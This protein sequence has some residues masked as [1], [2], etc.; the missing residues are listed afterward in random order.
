MRYFGI[1]VALL[2]GLGLSA[3]AT[4]HEQPYAKNTLSP[5][6]IGTE[7]LKTGDNTKLP[8]K[9]WMP[10][11]KPT[12]IIV[13]LH[14]FN[15]YSNAFA[16][17]AK[18]LS[19]SGV[20]VYAFDQ[21]GFGR[22]PQAGL[23]AG[24]PNLTADL[25]DMV[26]AVK[27]VHPNTPLYILGE[28]MGG[29]VA[30]SALAQPDFPKVNGLILVAPAVWGDDT[31]NSFY[32]LSLW[33]LAHM[34]PDNTA[35]GRDLRILASDNIPM[36]R[37]MGKDPYVLK[38]T[39]IDAVYGMVGLM[40][41]A[42]T[43]AENLDVPVLLLYGAKDQVI[44]PLPIKEV[45]KK[46]PQTDKVALYPLGYHMLLRDLNGHLVTNDILHWIRSKH[47]PLPSGYEMDPQR[48]V[49]KKALHEEVVNSTVSETVRPNKR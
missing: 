28:S 36:L 22:N 14:G 37:E 39:R 23:W 35:T 29:A 9:V 33:V 21:R 27:R 47:T 12:A 42:Y 45:S 46:L 18:R 31:M 1:I 25:A 17:P 38:S 48:F 11:K 34:V 44:P 10:E 43:H 15:D 20:G 7:T 30:I 5:Q 24:T 41:T 4:P 49:A 40:D 26:E 6:L 8:I 2:L 19:E 3:C 32:R 16:I 13:A